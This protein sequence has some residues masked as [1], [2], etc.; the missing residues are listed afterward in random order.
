MT[1]LMTKEWTNPMKSFSIV[2]FRGHN[3]HY[4]FVLVKKRLMD[5]QLN[6]SLIP[7]C[8]IVKMK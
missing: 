3:F 6:Y 2:R 7:S 4:K 5:D 1:L 8:K